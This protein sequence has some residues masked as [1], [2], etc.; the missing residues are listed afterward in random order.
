MTSYTHN[1][2][3]AA[4]VPAEEPAYEQYAAPLAQPPV[5]TLHA[6]ALWEAVSFIPYPTAEF[7]LPAEVA[8]TLAGSFNGEPLQG[9]DDE[10]VRVFIGQLPYFV[11]DMQLGWLCY[12]FGLG[13]GVL[14]PERIMKRQPCGERL[15]TGCVHAHCTRRA[16]GDMNEGMHKKLLIDDTGVWCAAN[17]E[18]FAALDAYVTAMKRDRSLRIPHRPYD[19]V[20]VQFATSTFVPH[21]LAAT[22]LS[23]MDEAP[24]RKSY[25]T[26]PPPAYHGAF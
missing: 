1:P 7:E 17:K 19:T 4:V 22:P 26:T 11:T 25:A 3:A 13:N 18:E 5:G 2:Y 8:A 21:S 16:V 20:V 9:S 14:F 15:P 6:A 12:T 24:R 10:L 23:A